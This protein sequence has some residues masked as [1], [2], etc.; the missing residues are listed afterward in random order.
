ML[1]QRGTLRSNAFKAA[2]KAV[3]A[4]L[5]RNRLWVLPIIVFGIGIFYTIIFIRPFADPGG[6][7]RLMDV[8]E[9]WNTSVSQ[10]GI[11]P[12]FPPQED[13]FVGDLWAVVTRAPDPSTIGKAVRIG[14]INL[15]DAVRAHL[16]QA[17]LIDEESAKPSKP[18]SNA[19]DPSIRMFALAFPGL[20]VTQAG[21]DASDASS[22]LF[23]FSSSRKEEVKDEIKIP[24]AK[25]YG[26]DLAESMV[27][28]YAF[29]AKP[30]SHLRCTGRFIR[31]IMA[32]A[33]DIRMGADSLDKMKFD[34][35][36]H[37]VTRVYLT[38]SIEHNRTLHGAVVFKGSANAS[39][40]L[41]ANEGS[42]SERRSDTHAEIINHEGA[43]SSEMTFD[44]HFDHPLVFGFRSA[45]FLPE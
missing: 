42:A 29:C 13:F 9:S 3:F 26:A 31:N 35:I 22:S 34:I 17:Y 14:H 30:E 4:W 6:S 16:S 32:A 11:S 27:A 24:S 12:L 10:L 43:N 19:D 36:V 8:S 20:S 33:V 7:T 1:L 41:K 39:G 18:T 38:K 45:M 40:E 21:D 25:T 23:S 5:R 2:F 44:E 15:E 37:L 28:Y